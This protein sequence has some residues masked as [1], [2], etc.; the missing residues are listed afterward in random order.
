MR[1]KSFFFKILSL[2]IIV[3]SVKLG[4]CLDSTCHEKVS[5]IKKDNEDKM[6]AARK[7]ESRCN[8]RS[9]NRQWIKIQNNRRREIKDL[10]NQFRSQ[11]RL[12]QKLCEKI[13]KKYLPFGLKDMVPNSL[14]CQF[15]EKSK[16]YESFEIPYHNKY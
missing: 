11:V 10:M 13:E 14:K 15:N 2:F 1:E 4:S 9:L 8:L 3:S 12:D 5:K 16:G 6:I 7:E